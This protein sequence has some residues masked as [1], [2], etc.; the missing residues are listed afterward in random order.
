MAQFYR[1]PVKRA[2]DA[3]AMRLAHFRRSLTIDPSLRW[4]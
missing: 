3:D 1:D 2:V 4:V